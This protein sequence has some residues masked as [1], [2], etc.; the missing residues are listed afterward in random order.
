MRSA[1]CV[2][3]AL[4]LVSPLAAESTQLT[5]EWTLDAPAASGVTDAGGQWNVSAQSGTLTLEERDGVLSG[6]WQGRLSDHSGP[7]GATARGRFRIPVRVP[8]SPR[9]DRRRQ[10]HAARRWTFNGTASGDTL[11]ETMSLDTESRRGPEQAF[12][13]ERQSSR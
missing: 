6:Q 1:T 12:S 8:G 11:T 9:G 13:A 10:D 5:G 4:V 3:S 7:Q 2:L